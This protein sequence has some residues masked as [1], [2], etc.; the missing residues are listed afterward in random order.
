MPG[1]LIDSGKY[2]SGE[3]NVPAVM[4][5]VLWRCGVKRAII[6]LTSKS[7]VQKIE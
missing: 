1:S 5:W 7:V 4:E 2:S 6:K 3:N